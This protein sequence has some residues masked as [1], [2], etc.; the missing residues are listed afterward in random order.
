MLYGSWSEGVL[1]GEFNTSS[2]LPE[3]LRSLDEQ[4]LAQFEIGVKADLS[5]SLRL[6]TAV[7]TLEWQDQLQSLFYIDPSLP[8]PIGYSDNQGTSDSNGVEA[9]ISWPATNGLALGLGFSYNHTEVNDFIST[10]ATDIAIT[11]DGDLSGNQMPLS[12]EWDAYASATYIAEFGEGFTLTSRVDVSYQDSRYV[13]VTNL[14][15]TGDATPVN[16]S[17]A[18]ERDSWRVAFWG[19]NVT[20]EDSAVSILRFLEADGFFFPTAFQVTPR[21]GAE[22]GVTLSYDF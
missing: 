16:L 12:P 1:P 2:L 5:G 21:T 6:T 22:W 14:A 19:K 20:D 4:R 15:E 9:D 17:L 3:N 10:D 11:G 13:R 8:S 7:Y 18:L